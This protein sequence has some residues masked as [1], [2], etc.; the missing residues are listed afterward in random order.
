MKNQE[1]ARKKVLIRTFGCQMNERDSQIICGLL[2]AAGHILCESDKE[3][4]AVIFNT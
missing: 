4:D 3:A 2:K 1:V